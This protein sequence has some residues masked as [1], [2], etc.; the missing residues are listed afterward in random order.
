M[1][2]DE[3]SMRNY[4]IPGPRVDEYLYNQIL[5]ESKK[6]GQAYVIRNAILLFMHFM[7]DDIKD[8]L[9]EPTNQGERTLK[10]QN[11]Y[12]FPDDYKKARELAAK[13]G[14]MSSF[15]RRALY[16]YLDFD[17]KNE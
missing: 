7:P 17:E 6:S 13:L 1:T 10:L 8:M 9:P 3:K 14:G 5:D 11:T 4:P 2:K 15:V 12:L 16:F